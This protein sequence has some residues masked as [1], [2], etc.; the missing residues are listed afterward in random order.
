MN[1]R[2]ALFPVLCAI[3]LCS[4]GGHGPVMDTGFLQKRKYSKGWDLQ[5][6]D[7]AD[8]GDGQRKVLKASVKDGSVIEPVDELAARISIEVP[9]SSDP[10]AAGVSLTESM[11]AAQIASVSSDAGFTNIP[12]TIIRTVPTSAAIERNAAYDHPQGPQEDLM[13]RKKWNMLAVPA[14]LSALGVVYLGLFQMQTLPVIIAIVITFIIAGISLRQ[15]RRK[16]QAGKGFAIAAL[17]IA[18]LATL[19][20]AMVTAVIGYV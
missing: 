11:E 13:P 20:T 6:L 4:C 16:E 9:R 3:I 19:Y 7:R 12:S 10:I 15:I 18:L 5:L 1:P 14:F 17:L 2:S 8:K